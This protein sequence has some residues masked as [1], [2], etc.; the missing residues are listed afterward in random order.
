M[1]IPSEVLKVC[2]AC[3]AEKPVTGF[4]SRNGGR[5]FDNT[6]RICVIAQN[7]ARRTGENREQVLAAESRYAR[8]MR[9]NVRDKVFAAYGGYRCICCG[10]TQP[11]FLTLDHINNDG[12]EWRKRVLGKRTHAGYHTYRWLLNNGCPPDVQVM[13]MN[14]Q[15]G[16][17][18]NGGIC[19]HQETRND[20]P[21]RE[22]GQVAGSA[23]PLN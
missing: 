2:K 14:C 9:S 19:P 16:K 10:E 13:C 5:W 20:Y 22:Y 7:K 21:A 17:L 1:E 18:T 23:A 3:G 8:K 11:K 6:C 4:Y 15:H 12:G